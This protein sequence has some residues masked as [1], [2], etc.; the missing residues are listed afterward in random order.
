MCYEIFEPKRTCA[1]MAIADNEH[2]PGKAIY[3]IDH[4]KSIYL[5]EKCYDNFLISTS[6]K[7]RE[8]LFGRKFSETA[9]YK[10]S[11]IFTS[12]RIKIYYNKSF[13]RWGIKNQNNPVELDIC[14]IK[15]PLSDEDKIK[16]TLIIQNNR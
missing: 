2:C 7:L 16:L 10:K 6:D 9:G 1:T 12:A 13:E 4:I 3:C 14:G 15:F 8:F 11:T 5:C